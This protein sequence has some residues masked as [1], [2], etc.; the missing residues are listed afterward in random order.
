VTAARLK[1]RASSTFGLRILFAWGMGRVVRM[2]A[3]LVW[4]GVLANAIFIQR[5]DLLYPSAFGSDT[6]NYVAFGERLAYGNDLY[7]LSPGDRPVPSDNPPLW[8]VPMLS[9]PQMAV[10]W[11]ALAVMPDVLRFYGLWSLGLAGS[12]A[13]GFLFVARAPIAMVI[14]G[15]TFFAGLATTALSGNVNAVIVP[16]GLLTWWVGSQQ[17]SRRWLIGVGAVV[18]L[19]AVVKI[20]P[21]IL[22]LWLVRRRGWDAAVAGGLAAVALTLVVLGMAGA[23]PFEAYLATS[24]ESAGD[25]TAQSIPGFLIGLGAAADL[26][27]VVWIILLCAM[28]AIVVFGRSP[29]GGFVAAVVATVFLTP[30]VRQETISLLL[31]AAAPWISNTGSSTGLRSVWTSAAVGLGIAAVCVAASLLGGGVNRSSM[32]IQNVSS[33]P[34]TVRFGVPM[35]Q[36]SWGYVLGPGQSGLAWTSQSGAILEP[37]RVFGRDCSLIGAVSPDGVSA[38]HIDDD[39]IS[40]VDHVDVALLLA[41]DAQCASAMPPLGAPVD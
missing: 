35:Q 27:R 19:V 16:I 25:P 28:A 29:R 31:V 1:E 4:V 13:L 30:I 8:S 3:L 9:P 21:A 34:V 6:S 36:A 20:G 18:A 32:A 7:A 39:T 38:I 2:V 11:A 24:L 12:L 40:A 26:A 17:S 15:A 23:S 37:I 22:W 14:I 33:E 10:P 41:Y 5:P